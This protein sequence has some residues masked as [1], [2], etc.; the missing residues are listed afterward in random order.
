V[1][2]IPQIAVKSMRENILQG[3]A[4]LSA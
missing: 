1:A 4:M 3:P 2:P